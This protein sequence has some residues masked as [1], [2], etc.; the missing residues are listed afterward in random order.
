MKKRF[1]LSLFVRRKGGNHKIAGATVNLGS[2]KGRGSS[3]R[4]FNYCKQT[5]AN[6]SGCINQFI[7]VSDNVV[8][9]PF[10]APIITNIVAGDTQ[11]TVIFTASTS[12]GGYN[13]INYQYST[14][15]GV[16][17]TSAGTII[18]P[19]TIT[20]LTN[21]TTY[22]VLIRAQNEVIFSPNSNVIS[23]T[24]VVT[25]TI[26]RYNINKG[27]SFNWDAV[28]FTLDGTLL[29]YSYTA[30]ITSTPHNYTVPSRDKLTEVTIGNTLTSIDINAFYQ[31]SSLTS[32]T[33]PNSVTNIGS[34]AFSDCTTLPSITIPASV[35]SISEGPFRG[36]SSL[37][38]IDVDPGNNNYLSVDGVLFNINQITILQYPAG[39]SSLLYTIPNS[40]TSIGAEAFYGCTALTSVTI[41]NF[42]TNINQSAFQSC[43]ALSS[44]I[45][46]NSVTS[47][48]SA[49]FQSSGL[50]SVTIPTNPKTISSIT[51]TAG[52]IVT[53]FGKTNVNI[54]GPP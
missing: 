7:N 29:D 15:N 51:F 45:I 25:P 18:S 37:I 39:K 35:T 41:G 12:N 21:G 44:I 47:I 30:I 2:T 53:F 31:C 26:L 42:V 16:N 38:S 34:D 52:T 6:P 33:I 43:T 27:S 32:V 3:T 20:G 1:N 4:M 24:P 9:I 46:P 14:N 36:G 28:T 50:T 23:A 48:G 22:Q 10:S 40:V 5:S 11:L 54:I 13:I 49:A 17:F 8:V 19:I